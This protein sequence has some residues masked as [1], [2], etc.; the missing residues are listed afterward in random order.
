MSVENK[1]H[2]PSDL[3]K[4]LSNSNV[5][6]LDMER[7]C[8]RGVYLCNAKGE[9]YSDGYYYDKLKDE[10]TGNLL[11]LKVP[12]VWKKQLK[13]NTSYVLEGTI[14]RKLINSFNEL[15]LH[16]AFRLTNIVGEEAPLIN[17]KL[18][19]A[20]AILSARRAKP[21][22]YV[23]A[24]IR[25][26]FKQDRKPRVAMISPRRGVTDTDVERAIEEQ[27]H[28]YDVTKVPISLLNKTE[29]IDTLRRLDA[30]GE[31][32][33]IAIFRGGGPGLDVFEDNDIARVVVGMQTSLV[34][35]IGHA[36]DTPF[37]ESVADQ[38]FTTPSTLGHHLQRIAEMMVIDISWLDKYRNDEQRYQQT[39][40]KM[41]DEQGRADIEHQQIVK[42]LVGERNALQTEVKELYKQKTDRPAV[43][44]SSAIY[45][46]R[47]AAM[48]LITGVLVGL[49][50]EL[51]AAYLFTSFGQKA[52][53][54]TPTNQVQSSPNTQQ[55]IA[56]TPQSANGKIKLSN[57][58]VQKR[59][60]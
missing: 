13:P 23:E 7:V 53:M 1:P 58:K 11:T 20:T 19:E 4:T 12:E 57:S 47:K 6:R 38:A 22:Q 60:H 15:G 8:V 27:R 46:T 24:I 35:G 28:N 10:V 37:I 59:Q 43:V 9:K 52:P 36:E 42:N 49:I 50:L 18:R 29:I 31:Y 33:L 17:E 2:T 32:D 39:I 51:I 40:R 3:V 25:E 34:T 16:L 45:S 54:A 48:L 56:A 14:D 44:E 5:Q 55:T 26:C 30:S 41:K 21:R